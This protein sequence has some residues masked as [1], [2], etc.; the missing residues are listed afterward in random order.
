MSDEEK[1]K[2]VMKEYLF[3]QEASIGFLTMNYDYKQKEVDKLV[4]KHVEGLSQ[5]EIH[6]YNALMHTLI[7]DK[8]YLNTIKKVV[9][10]YE[11]YA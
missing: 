4:Y 2:I 10:D 11:R 1:M 7:F 8:K 6:L 9:T 5:D 3:N